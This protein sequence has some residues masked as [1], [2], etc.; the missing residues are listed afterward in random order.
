MTN[1]NHPLTKL[2]AKQSE[3]NVDVYQQHLLTKIL[4]SQKSFIHSL[5]DYWIIFV[6]YDIS[7]SWSWL[8]KTKRDVG[9]NLIDSRIIQSFL[10][11]IKAYE[12]LEHLCIIDL[13]L[14]ANVYLCI[15][16]MYLYNRPRSWGQ[17]EPMSV[18]PASASQACVLHVKRA[19][20]Q[21]CRRRDLV[22]SKGTSTAAE[23]KSTSAREAKQSTLG[24]TNRS[25]AQELCTKHGITDAAPLCVCVTVCHAASGL[26][27]IFNFQSA[28]APRLIKPRLMTIL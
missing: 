22:R 7:W 16:D 27:H 12:E 5:L 28:V 20:R 4:S 26:R 10:H 14:E 2:S 13:E 24:S 6:S 25:K 11:W 19:P 18:C 8:T 9:L 21:K 17:C 23:H 3:I 1:I 15:C